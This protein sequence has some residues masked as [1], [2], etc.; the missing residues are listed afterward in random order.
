VKSKWAYPAEKLLMIISKKPAIGDLHFGLGGTMSHDLLRIM[1]PAWVG[2]KGA[3][4]RQKARYERLNRPMALVGS[5]S[6]FFVWGKDR[7]R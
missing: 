2:R 7:K 6:R 3:N 5:A 4:K 1:E